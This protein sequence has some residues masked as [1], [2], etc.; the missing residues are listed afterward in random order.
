MGQPEMPFPHWGGIGEVTYTPTLGILWEQKH[1]H[2]RSVPLGNQGLQPGRRRFV[3]FESLRFRHYFSTK[4][5]TIRGFC[6]SGIWHKLPSVITVR[7]PCMSGLTRDQARS[8]NQ[9]FPVSMQRPRH[10]GTLRQAGNARVQRAL[11][12]RH[13]PLYPRFRHH[14]PSTPSK[15]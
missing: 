4:A 12:L 9:S 2:K 8:A 5:P 11:A 15:S 13:S 1:L 3:E 14:A 10:S 6:V 7:R